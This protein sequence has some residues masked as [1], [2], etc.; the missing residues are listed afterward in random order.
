MIAASEETVSPK[1]SAGAVFRCSLA[2]VTGSTD[3]RVQH[4]SRAIIEDI[5]TALLIDGSQWI[6]RQVNG[7]AKTPTEARNAIASCAP[8]N[9][10][11]IVTIL[12]AP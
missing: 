10:G 12:I 11:A 8:A 6:V 3:L 7:S 5:Q 2:T 9:S 4:R 1:E